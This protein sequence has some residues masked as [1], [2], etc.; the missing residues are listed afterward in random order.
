MAEQPTSSPGTQATDG[1]PE[2]IRNLPRRRDHAPPSSQARV[3]GRLIPCAAQ[4]PPGPRSA[5]AP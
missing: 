5:A 3:G 1:L 2:P 4:E